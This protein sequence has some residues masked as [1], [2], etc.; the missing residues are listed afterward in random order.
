M[1]L[2]ASKVHLHHDGIAETDIRVLVVTMSTNHNS[3]RSSI[4]AEMAH[5]LHFCPY[6]NMI[7]GTYLVLH[8]A[9][10]SLL[11]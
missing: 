4:I 6:D 9:M 10:N 1:L 5:F 3:S 8:S 7:A 2:S 11:A